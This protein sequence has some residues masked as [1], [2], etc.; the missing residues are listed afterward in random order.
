ML[1]NLKNVDVAGAV[2]DAGNPI[3]Q[4]SEQAVGEDVKN[5]TWCTIYELASSGLGLSEPGSPLHKAEEYSNELPEKVDKA[6][7]HH[8]ASFLGRLNH[9]ASPLTPL[10]NAAVLTDKGS[11]CQGEAIVDAVMELSRLCG[12]VAEA[13]TRWPDTQRL[14]TMTADARAQDTEARRAGLLENLVSQTICDV[15]ANRIVGKR[16]RNTA[17]PFHGMK[18][19]ASIRRSEC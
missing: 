7:E 16:E 11:L 4:A 3:S 13:C 12:A 15:W 17:N 1:A 2:R 14:A 8:N 5:A 18:A 19:D 6:V 10:L 9:R